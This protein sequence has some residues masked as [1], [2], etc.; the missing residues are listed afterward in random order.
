[1]T[2]LSNQGGGGGGGLELALTEND[3]FLKC[4]TWLKK[5]KGIIDLTVF[6]KWFFWA[7]LLRYFVIRKMNVHHVT[8]KEWRN[9]DLFPSVGVY[10]NSIGTRAVT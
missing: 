7:W 10:N 4:P 2:V 6:L 1:M 8:G 3:G 9:F 5:Y